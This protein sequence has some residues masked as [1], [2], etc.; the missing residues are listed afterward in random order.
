MPKIMVSF[1]RRG[2]DLGRDTILGSTIGNEMQ[3]GEVDSVG[4][5]FEFQT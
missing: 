5:E 2:F 4:V 1:A 3:I